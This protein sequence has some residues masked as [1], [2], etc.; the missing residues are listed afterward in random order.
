MT[1]LNTGK[2]PCYTLKAFSHYRGAPFNLET[3]LGHYDAPALLLP[4]SLLTDVYFLCGMQYKSTQI[5]LFL[6]R[7]QTADLYLYVVSFVLSSF[8]HTILVEIVLLSYLTS[9]LNHLLNVGIKKVLTDLIV[10][11]ITKRLNHV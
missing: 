6:Y 9:L 7:V 4:Y 1:I 11:L 8:T 5:A 10:N 3:Y 2:G